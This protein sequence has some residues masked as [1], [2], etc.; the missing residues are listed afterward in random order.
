MTKLQIR[1]RLIE[2]GISMRQFALTHGYDPRTVTQTIDRWAG[3]ATLPSGR[4]AFSIMHALS[5]QIGSEL[6]PGLL[7][8]PFAKAS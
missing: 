8:H 5:L 4:I 7:N 3:S 6:I 1:A 2:Q